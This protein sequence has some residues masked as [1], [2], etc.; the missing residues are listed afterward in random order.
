VGSYTP[1]AG[2]GI[3]A[4]ETDS[5]LILN[6]DPFIGLLDELRFSDVALAPSE[7]MWVWWPTVAYWQ[8]DN[9]DS[10][11]PS[12]ALTDSV[13]SYDLSVVGG[14]FVPSTDAAANPVPTPDTTPVFADD[15]AANPDGGTLVRASLIAPGGTANNNYLQ[16]PSDPGNVFNLSGKSFT[17]EGWFR[18]K[19]TSNPS[20]FGDIIGGS[21]NAGGYDGWLLMMIEGGDIRAV[22]S[23]ET[24]W[25]ITTSGTDY[26][27]ATEFHHFALVWEDG[28][29][30][31]STGFASIYIDGVLEASGSAPADWSAADADAGDMP[32]I[33]GGR[34]PSSD[35][36]W[37]GS[38]DEFRF[39]EIA[40][41]PSEFLNYTPAGTVISIQ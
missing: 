12:E 15:P 29:G 11:T 30:T 1:A 35:N 23:E 37:D 27:S 16:V 3:G 36:T 20:A 39:S 38:F 21:R 26:R 22:F 28:A 17:F 19:T 4:R 32:F 41:T 14:G 34:A 6:D 5:D 10:A 9:N 8:F 18:H 24:G 13:G 33:I 25:W 40:L 7:F 2:F 31:N